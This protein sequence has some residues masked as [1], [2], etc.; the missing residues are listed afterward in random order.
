MNSDYS[1]ILKEIKKMGVFVKSFLI[2][3][4]FFAKYLEMYAMITNT[5]RIQVFRPIYRTNS[6]PELF[7]P[8][9]SSIH[10][11]KSIASTSRTQTQKTIYRHSNV[12]RRLSEDL[13]EALLSTNSRHLNPSHDG[14]YSSVNT[15]LVRYG[16]GVAVG[17]GFGVGVMKL[18][19]NNAKELPTS[20]TSTTI[21]TTTT[22]DENT[23]FINY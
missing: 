4:L 16:I 14:Y 3:V 21:P 1:R 19:N 23:V 11:G 22:E 13:N 15:V 20:T 12:P 5:A 10:R 7:I 18:Y 17:T 8:S 9:G 6:A 2:F